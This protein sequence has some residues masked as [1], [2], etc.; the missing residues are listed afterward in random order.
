MEC[1]RSIVPACPSR[2]LPGHRLGLPANCPSRTL[3]PPRALQNNHFSGSDRITKPYL[4]K[5]CQTQRSFAHSPGERAAN[6][7]P[8]H[9]QNRGVVHHVREHRV[10]SPCSKLVALSR[11]N[12]K[13][14]DGRPTTKDYVKK[15]RQGQGNGNTN[16]VWSRG[17]RTHTTPPWIAVVTRDG[18]TVHLELLK[19]L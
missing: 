12:I 16:T 11:G 3:P 15:G 18:S 1:L 5:Y 17:T 19:D 9:D 2:Y 4:H 7:V 13:R 14:G 8:S 6:R 10:G